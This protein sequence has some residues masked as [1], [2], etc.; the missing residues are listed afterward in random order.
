MPNALV[1]I[2]TIA[3]RALAVAHEKLQ[4]IGTVNRDYDEEFGRAGKKAGDTIRIRN[5]NQYT[6]RQGSRVMNTQAQAETTQN[7]TVS[8]QDGVDM[9]WNGAEMTLSLDEYT[10]RYISPAMDIL[11]SGIE[12]DFLQAMTKATANT[13]GTKGTVPG[14]STTTVLGDAR[15]MLNMNLAPKGN[16][17]AQ[18]DSTTMASLG[19]A[20]RG[21]YEDRAQIKEAMREGF[22][23]RHS[24]FDWYENER[25]LTLAN[26]DDVTANTN[27]DALVTDGGSSIAVSEDLAQAKQVVGSVFTVAGVYAC[28]AET[29]A[30]YAHL[31]QFT[32]TA[33]GAVSA[34]VT[35][36]IY[37]TGAKKN[38]GSVTGAD[39]AVTVF[40]EA[41]LTF[42]GAASA[43]VKYGLLYDK[44][45]F[46]FATADLPIMKTGECVRKQHD[47]LSLRLWR[48]GDIVNDR[49]L[50]RIDILYGWLA[51]RPAHAVRM[52]L[53]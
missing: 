8:I 19:N 13:V 44:D 41:T 37:L 33:T 25:I 15:A 23:S 2:D 32:I 38:V 29:K 35:P 34:T 7:L 26:S 42:I 12:S 21:F 18:I 40:N 45:A 11:V 27:A 14:A 50:L 5:P 49:E 43:S 4:F 16:R 20:V 1:T 36:T 31:Q 48:S 51:M 39:L 3:D 10:K 9:E 52:I 17:S 24:G 22:I 28:H 30:P 46:T 53:N 47:G 6:R